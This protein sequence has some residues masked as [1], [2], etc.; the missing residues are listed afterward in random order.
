MKISQSSTFSLRFKG[1]TPLACPFP[2]NPSSADFVKNVAL[3]SAVETMHSNKRVSFLPA[4]SWIT[5][6]NYDP[7]LSDHDLTML[8]PDDSSYS[9]V[10]AEIFDTKESF[11]DSAVKHFKSHNLRDDVI[12]EKLLPSINVFPTPKVQ[13]CFSSYDQFRDCTNLKIS[14]HP[15]VDNDTGLW[16]MKGVV[17]SHFQNEGDLLYLKEDG[18][19]GIF[20]I[21]NH[22]PEFNTYLSKKEIYMQKESTLYSSD[23]LNIINEFIGKMQQSDPMD[24]RTFYKYLNRV[25]KFFFVGSENDLFLVSQ[26]PRKIS[27]PK[28]ESR[29]K[30]ERDYLDQF[31]RIAKSFE[32]LKDLPQDELPEKFARETSKQLER[33][34]TLAEDILT[35]PILRGFKLH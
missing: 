11:K 5:G 18:S 1:R 10:E 6:I 31:E 30:L 2:E 16:K 22:I 3:N 29:I 17:L 14:L 8:L 35:W 33:F 27:S 25:K 4:G 12:D 21:K 32:S 13:E 24:K 7:K 34:K 15:K 9:N 23:K 19:I 20:R 28:F 26:D